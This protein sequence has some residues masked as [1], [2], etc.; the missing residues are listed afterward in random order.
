ME[1]HL[2]ENFVAAGMNFADISVTWL[3]KHIQHGSHAMMQH[4]KQLVPEADVLSVHV[5]KPIEQSVLVAVSPAATRVFTGMQQDGVDR[6][7]SITGPQT[8]ASEIFGG[9]VGTSRSGLLLSP[10]TEE[11]RVVNHQM[12]AALNN[13][14]KDPGAIIDTILSASDQGYG[15]F[16]ACLHAVT[17]ML[18][19]DFIVSN[20]PNAIKKMGRQLD[21]AA[22]SVFLRTNRTA[23]FAIRQFFS[24]TSKISAATTD[25]FHTADAQNGLAGLHITT[26]SVYWSLVRLSQY[27]DADAKNIAYEV[28]RHD[29]SPVLSMP[30]APL[31]IA[32]PFQ[33][34]VTSPTAVLSSKEF[35]N[36]PHT[37]DPERYS[38]DA[39]L[40]AKVTR[41]AFGM[42]SHHCPAANFMPQFLT[43]IVESAK[44]K[45]VHHV[46]HPKVNFLQL[47]VKQPTFRSQ[48]YV[49]N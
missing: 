44:N 22:I 47:I 18:S 48:G 10:T 49:T 16:D 6:H 45:G 8:P 19:G 35:G 25:K 14:P 42:G 4:V 7:M 39:G 21:I 9:S 32:D 33:I 37:F 27:P 38:N 28:L 12:R 1:R 43:S 23:Q 2:E 36:N 20:H 11:T 24:G 41:S 30:R 26:A 3:N 31:T 46:G 40:Y 34:A 13:T 15:A 17:K 5:P 29:A